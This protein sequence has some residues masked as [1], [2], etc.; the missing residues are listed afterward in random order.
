MAEDWSFIQNEGGNYKEYTELYE[1]T[2]EA[3]REAQRQG[4]AQLK[5]AMAAATAAPVNRVR[6]CPLSSAFNKA[7]LENTYWQKSSM[8]ADKKDVFLIV[9]QFLVRMAVLFMLIQNQSSESIAAD[10]VCW[11]ICTPKLLF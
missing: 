6:I 5:A 11:L 3:T 2:R 10:K 7:G 9:F 1:R 8:S 4:D